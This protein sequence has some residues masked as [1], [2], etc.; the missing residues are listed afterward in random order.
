MKKIHTREMLKKER[1]EHLDPNLGIRTAQ[2]ITPHYGLYLHEIQIY[3]TAEMRMGSVTRTTPAIQLVNVYGNACPPP[4]R[5]DHNE[6][7][8]QMNS[9]RTCRC[10]QRQHNRKRR[11]CFYSAY[12]YVI[13][14]FLKK[15]K[16]ATSHIK[17]HLLMRLR[18]CKLHK[19]WDMLIL[20]AKLEQSL[21]RPSRLDW[22]A[23]RLR[24]NMKF[25]KY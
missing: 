19:S 10:T 12:R 21:C 13:H 9:S 16:K 25:L 20:T 3:Q 17:L 18:W 7:F 11:K 2:L 6:N 15:M 4:I 1:I 23:I 8:P 22:I 14:V 24:K 5:I